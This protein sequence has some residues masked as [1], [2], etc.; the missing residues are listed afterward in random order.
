MPDAATLIE[1]IRLVAGIDE[2][3]QQPGCQL[4]DLR[5]LGSIRLQQATDLNH[6]LDAEA[7]FNALSQP[8]H[9]SWDQLAADLNIHGHGNGH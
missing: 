6:G 9:P 8:K 3:Q 5:D 1:W 4:E 2:R 7:W